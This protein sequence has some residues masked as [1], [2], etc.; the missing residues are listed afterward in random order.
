MALTM[1]LKAL[2]NDHGL[3]IALTALTMPLTLLNMALMV[4][5]RGNEII[6]PK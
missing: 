2:T 1:A 5:V 4:V 6:I 3:T